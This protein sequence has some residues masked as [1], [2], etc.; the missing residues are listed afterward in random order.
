LEGDEA[1]PK[2]H[3]QPV[4]EPVDWSVKFTMSGAQPAVGFA[5]KLAVT[6]AKEVEANSQQ[7]IASKENDLIRKNN[8]KQTELM[9]Q[10]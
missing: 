3:V 8:F 7:L 1:S 10:I 9:F 2:F 4:G 5:V 6:C